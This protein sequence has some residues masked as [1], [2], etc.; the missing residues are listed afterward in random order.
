MYLLAI[1]S[2]FLDQY[3]PHCAGTNNFLLRMASWGH[4]IPYKVL[5][6]VPIAEYLMFQYDLRKN[7]RKKL[8]FFNLI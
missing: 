8:M 4:Q 3:L 1:C 7:P 6:S 5:F 2:T